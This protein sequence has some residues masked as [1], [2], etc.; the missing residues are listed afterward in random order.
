MLYSGACQGNTELVVIPC[1]SKPLLKALYTALARNAHRMGNP[2]KVVSPELIDW[3]ANTTT[4]CLPSSVNSAFASSPRAKHFK[5]LPR[6]RSGSN[7]DSS[8][9]ATNSDNSGIDYEALVREANK[10]GELDGYR[11]G[12]IN[13]KSYGGGHAGSGGGVVGT[14]QDVIHRAQ[15]QIHRGCRYWRQLDETLWHLIYDWGLAHTNLASCRCCTTLIINHS[16]SPIQ[17]T[18]IQMMMGRQVVIMGSEATGYEAESRLIWSR[19]Y[20]VVF[21]CAFPQSP[22]EVGHLKAKINSVAFTGV[23]AST[24]RETYCEAKS[25]FTIGFL[26]KSVSEWWSKYVVHIS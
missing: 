25:G 17:I 15:D 3:N 23:I 24:Q 19:G 6:S 7:T 14:E 10:V 1:K 9:G 11:F 21:V 22:L 18:R 16:D 5:P 2:S 26:E 20:V 12:S 13:G 4:P 8:P